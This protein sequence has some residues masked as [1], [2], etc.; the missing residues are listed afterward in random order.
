MTILFTGYCGDQVK[1]M[2]C[3]GCIAYMKGDEIMWTKFLRDDLNE[4]D[5]LGKLG[6]DWRT[7]LKEILK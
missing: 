6:I 5:H 4:R 2:Q 1:R 7:L 3:A